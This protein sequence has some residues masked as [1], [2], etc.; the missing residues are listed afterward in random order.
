ME[1]SDVL[2]WAL[3]RGAGKAIK[4]QHL[5]L[6]WTLLLRGRAVES[7]EHSIFHGAKLLENLPGGFLVGTLAA[8]LRAKGFCWGTRVFLASSEA[9]LSKRV[10]G[11]ER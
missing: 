2:D 1:F 6:G 9:L 11:L 8:A 4:S 7:N 5:P 3:L 10:E